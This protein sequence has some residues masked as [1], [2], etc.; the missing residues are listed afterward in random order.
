MH[1]GRLGEHN[2]RNAPC[3]KPAVC[4]AQWRTAGPARSHRLRSAQNA[5][6][7]PDDAERCGTVVLGDRAWWRPSAKGAQE[8]RR[9]HKHLG[10]RRHR[11]HCGTGLLGKTSDR[12]DAHRPRSAF[13][14][15]TVPLCHL[16]ALGRHDATTGRSA[17]GASACSW[18]VLGG[19]NKGEVDKVTQAV[20]PRPR[21]AS[22]ARAGAPSGSAR[23]S[24]PTK[25]ARRTSW[26][27]C[28]AK[29]GS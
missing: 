29:K 9:L 21:R 22:R 2:A 16:L 5:T 27:P 10:L 24:C 6:R 1:P 18:H 4:P 13:H 17:R 7:R 14:I 23:A 11:W 19:D 25:I 3:P 15:A 8:L 26:G 12:R 20:L 28:G